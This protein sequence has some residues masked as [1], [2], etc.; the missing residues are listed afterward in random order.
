MLVY[1]ITKAKSLENLGIWYKMFT[2]NQEAP[3]I[4]V[5]NKV[6]LVNGR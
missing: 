2:E 1:D 3:G 5:G 6:D 4:V